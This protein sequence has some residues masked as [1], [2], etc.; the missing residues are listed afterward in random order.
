[1]WPDVINGTFEFLG[2]AVM[3]LS[4]RQVLKDKMVRGLHW[5]P[6]VF[7]GAWGWW[8]LFYYPSL[9]QWFSLAGGVTLVCVETVWLILLVRYWKC[10][11]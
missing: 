1:M 11:R 9:D 4:V 6:C 10:G 5:A 7:F 3:T 8:N 2:A